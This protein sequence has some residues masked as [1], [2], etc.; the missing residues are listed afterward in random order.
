MNGV[1]KINRSF[2]V[3]GEHVIVAE[4]LGSAAHAPSVSAMHTVTVTSV[5]AEP[6]GIGSAGSLGG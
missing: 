3:D 4:C 5:A 2:N 6:G 1:A